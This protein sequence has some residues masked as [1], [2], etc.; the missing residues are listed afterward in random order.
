MFLRLCVF[1]LGR[2]HS[3]LLALVLSCLS[4]AVLCF[5][6]SSVVSMPLRLCQGLSLAGVFMSSYITSEYPAPFLRILT[7]LESLSDINVRFNFLLLIHLEFKE[8]FEQGH[9]GKLLFTE[10]LYT[11]SYFGSIITWIIKDTMFDLV[12][13]DG[14]K[15]YCDFK[16]CLI[17]VMATLVS[18]DVSIF[19]RSTVWIILDC[20]M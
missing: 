19:Y 20:S 14:K 15:E 1:R 10:C 13:P 9:A 5:S 16:V 17:L 12:P 11:H 6:V 3:F 2:R 18:V 7:Y 8:S 4:G